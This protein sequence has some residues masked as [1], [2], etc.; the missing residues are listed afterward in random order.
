MANNTSLPMMRSTAVVA[1]FGGRA[2]VLHSIG[3]G[4][5]LVQ[6]ASAALRRITHTAITPIHRAID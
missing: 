3:H 6:K 4:V 1:Q 2:Q 5:L